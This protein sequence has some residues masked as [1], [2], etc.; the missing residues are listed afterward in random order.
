MIKRWWWHCTGAYCVVSWNTALF[1]GIPKKWWYR[2]SRERTKGLHVEDICGWSGCLLGEAQE[3]EAN[4]FAAS[5]R[6]SFIIV[7]ILRIEFRSSGR[8]GIPV[9]ASL[10][11]G[12]SGQAQA[13]YQSYAVIGRRLW[14]AL[15][16]RYLWWIV[17]GHSIEFLL[18]GGSNVL[19]GTRLQVT[20]AQTIV[21]YFR[22]S[23][24]AGP[25]LDDPAALQW[26]LS[27]HK[28][29]RKIQSYGA[30]NFF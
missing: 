9:V 4:D 13:H 6:E 25:E 17:P 29:E 27:L 3:A 12:F 11:R 22:L 2:S 5:K 18:S 23:V 26:N 20:D 24:M 15:P 19:I 8:L 7:W 16:G 30:I 10:S 1:C 21:V 14:N 28:G